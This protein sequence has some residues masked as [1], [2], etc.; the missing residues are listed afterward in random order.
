MPELLTRDIDR[1]GTVDYV[2]FVWRVPGVYQLRVV[3]ASSPYW[4]SHYVGRSV[5]VRS[6]LCQH[7]SGTR[8]LLAN[9]IA[10]DHVVAR[11]LTLFS[12]GVSHRDLAHTEQHWIDLLQPDLNK[13]LRVGAP[14]G[15]DG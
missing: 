4:G 13:Q 12:G 11:A 5:N 15:R 14:I 3:A 9:G 1:V 8:P 10:A 7:F 2:P 6:R